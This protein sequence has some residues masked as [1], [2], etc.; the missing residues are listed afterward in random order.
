[1]NESSSLK[2]LEHF[3]SNLLIDSKKLDI[4]YHE[5]TA[6]ITTTRILKSVKK[7]S[8]CA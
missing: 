1:M 4:T 2:A 5:D 8:A 7:I 3:V 6:E